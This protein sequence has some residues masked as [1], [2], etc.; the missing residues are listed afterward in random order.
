M[1]SGCG[2]YV[3]SCPVSV[4]CVTFPS[5]VRAARPPVHRLSPESPVKRR[6]PT[7]T[8]VHRGGCP[9][10]RGSIGR[11]SRAGLSGRVRCVPDARR[12]VPTAGCVPDT[13]RCL[14]GVCTITFAPGAPAVETWRRGGAPPLELARST[15]PIY[16]HVAPNGGHC[17]VIEA[18]GRSIAGLR[19]GIPYGGRWPSTYVMAFVY[20][21]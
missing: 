5:I 17:P 14:P 13:R 8:A 18:S 21:S 20:P 6:S 16:G 12:G 3:I 15:D 10:S 2:R 9:A 4:V 7:F 1:A 19:P 11:V